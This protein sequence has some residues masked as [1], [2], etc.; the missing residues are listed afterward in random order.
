MPEHPDTTSENHSSS[1]AVVNVIGY[2]FVPLD[3]LVLR[4]ADLESALRES[5]VKGTVLLAEEGINVALAGPPAAIER[6][7]AVLDADPAT[8][9][10]WL[11]RSTSPTTPFAKLKVRVR[12]EIIAFDGDGAPAPRPTAPSVSPDELEDWLREGRDV[13]LLDTR[14]DYEL[15][16]GG[17]EGATSL[18][19]GHFRDFKA[20]VER[21]LDEGRLRLEQPLVT[22]C[23]G[24]I[25]CEKAAPWLLER[26]FES[27]HQIEGGV[28]NWFERQGGA[29]WRGDCFV[30]DD[31]VS[32]TPALRPSGARLCRRCHRAVPADAGCACDERPDQPSQTAA[33]TV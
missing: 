31:R 24:G 2:R 10:L 11:K 27:V 1:D 8:A 5:G 13:T 3:L 25:R 12:R 19:I 17:F 15:E 6:A 26:G 7:R 23:T 4:Q 30:F 21:A 20:A 18:G 29:R 33:D 28:L 9:G 16:A 22:F 32:V 14:N